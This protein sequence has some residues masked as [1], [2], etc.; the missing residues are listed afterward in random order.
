MNIIGQHLSN[1]IGEP[2]YVSVFY[3]RLCQVALETFKIQPLIEI[4]ELMHE[5]D[6]AT[7][8]QIR[9]G[10]MR[11]LW[12]IEDIQIDIPRVFEFMAQI[13]MG[14]KLKFLVPQKILT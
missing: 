9:R 7:K 6:L 12:K 5:V 13:L 11:L 3:S 14:L 1:D 8:Q 2:Q 4:S 10:L